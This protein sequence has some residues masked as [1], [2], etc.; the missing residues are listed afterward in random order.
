MVTVLYLLENENM[1]NVI[2]SAILY[3]LTVLLAFITQTNC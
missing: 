1:G 3:T 2:L